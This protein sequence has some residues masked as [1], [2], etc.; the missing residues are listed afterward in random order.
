MT[1][2]RFLPAIALPVPGL[3]GRERSEAPAR[4]ASPAA[5]THAA[6]RNEPLLTMPAR[7][8][9]LIGASAAVYAVTLAGVSGLQSQS[10]AEAIARREPWLAE[11]AESRAAN[12]DLDA[13]LVAAGA[14][15]RA[16]AAAY[17]R[18]G[19]AMTSYQARLDTLAA[20]VAE[21]QGSAASLPSRINLPAVN[22]RSSTRSTRP[23]TTATSGASGG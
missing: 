7:A 6:R 14:E 13:S 11:I 23:A 19:D 3:L 21:V 1:T 5:A 9:M 12:D 22:V 8:G 2:E 15:A 10:D 18:T 20:L 4:R 17:A 16:L